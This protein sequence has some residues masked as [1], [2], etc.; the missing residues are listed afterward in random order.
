MK[1]AVEGTSTVQHSKMAQADALSTHRFAW[2][3]NTARAVDPQSAVQ[4]NGGYSVVT[5]SSV[6]GD[7]CMHAN[8]ID[9][10]QANATRMPSN[11]HFK[12]GLCN[13]INVALQLL[14]ALHLVVSDVTRGTIGV[15]NKC[16]CWCTG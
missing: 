4:Q 10:S 2:A 16:S 12:I 9:E 6:V 7:A 13:S 1:E 8:C 5:S 3:D 14:H 11:Q 15:L